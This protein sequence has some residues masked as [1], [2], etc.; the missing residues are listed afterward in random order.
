MLNKIKKKIK[1]TIRLFRYKVVNGNTY[2]PQA[3]RK[4]KLLIYLEQLFF[5]WHYGCY[6]AFYF[7]YG[8]DRKEMTLK[9]IREEYITPYPIFQEREG[10]LNTHYPH[11]S[12]TGVVLTVDKFYFSLFLEKLNMPTPHV[13]CYIKD[14]Q[15]IY[16]DP[17]YK[18]DSSSSIEQKLSQLLSYNMDVFCKPSG[19]K[20]GNGSF[21]MR[22][23]D[24]QIFIDGVQNSVDNVIEMLLSDDYLIQERICQ[25]PE[26]NK[27][28][29]TAV[30]TIRI[31][32][33]VREDGSILA[34]GAGLRMGREG[35]I[36]DNWS[37][38]GVF[39]G[40]D[41]EK[42]ALKDKGF[43]KPQY[44]TVSFCHPD[45]Q[46]VFKDFIIPYYKE[47]ERLVIEAH[48]MFY[49]CY[50]VGWDIAIT[51]KG[52]VIIEANSLWGLS[53]IQAAHGGLKKQIGHYFDL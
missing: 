17:Q 47:A 38:G 30:N 11:F 5:I 19:G 18:L 24:S 37:K 9:R 13:L 49:R 26:L 27:L 50:S 20:K 35:S 2:Y 8:F 34:F 21:K 52:P 45:T 44:G 15:I 41:M 12:A 43:L 28:C 6:E 53:L 31:Q 10:Y 14:G 1:I 36:V 33:I 51:E 32:T 7:L 39:V 40:I 22:I 48:K 4:P 25:H 23:Q 3:A 46:V 16:V 42:G 29:S